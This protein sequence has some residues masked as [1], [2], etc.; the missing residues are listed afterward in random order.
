MYQH[1]FEKLNVWQNSINLVE[2]VCNI[3][4]TFPKE[5]K[6]GITNQMKRYSVS[7]SSNLAEGTSRITQKDKA[8]FSNIAFSSTME[9]LCQVTIC[10]RLEFIDEDEYLKLRADIMKISNQINTLRKSQLTN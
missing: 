10:K 1:S 4:K 9:L 6:F 7:I 5:E 2:A 3:T 8:H